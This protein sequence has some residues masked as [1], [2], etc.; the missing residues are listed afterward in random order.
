MFLLQVDLLDDV[1]DVVADMEGNPE[2]FSATDPD[3]FDDL[4]KIQQQDLIKLLN[5]LSIVFCLLHT[6]F[7]EI[8]SDLYSIDPI[9]KF[10]NSDETGTFFKQLETDGH[11][12]RASASD[13]KAM[14]GIVK[15]CL[16]RYLDQTKRISPFHHQ[17]LKTDCASKDLPES[18][19][20][21]DSESDLL[22]IPGKVTQ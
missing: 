11:N 18:S 4:C 9:Y 2:K 14:D 20:S 10:L 19:L 12:K 17:D 3:M 22:T 8:L 5:F 7:K 16:T 15:V 21:N 13:T 6:V 1:L